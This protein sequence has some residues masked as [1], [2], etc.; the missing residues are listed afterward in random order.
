VILLTVDGG[1]LSQKDLE[2][3]G[4]RRVFDKSTATPRQIAE[5]IKHV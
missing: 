1:R 2:N 4:V 5:A 3:Y